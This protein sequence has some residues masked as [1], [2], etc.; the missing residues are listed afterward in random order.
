M[1][2]N[3]NPTDDGTLESI[4]DLCTNATDQLNSRRAFMS[5]TV[6]A[7]VGIGALSFAG[8]GITAAG[9]KSR[10]YGFTVVPPAKDMHKQD[11]KCQYPSSEHGFALYA[12]HGKNALVPVNLSSGTFNGKKASPISG[13]N[14]NTMLVGLDYRPSNGT[15]YALD[16]NGQL[17][18]ISMPK[19]HGNAVSAQPVGSPADY[20]GADLGDGIGFDFNP[21]ADA[22]RVV[23]MT[24][25]SF[26]TN[27]DDGTIIRQDPDTFYA[28]GDPNEGTAPQLSAAAYTNSVPDPTTTTLYD[29][30]SNLD[31]LVRQNADPN[32]PNTSELTTIGGLG[33][34]VAAIN[35]FDISGTTGTAYA[36]LTVDGKTGLYTV[37]LMSGK[38]TQVTGDG[39]DDTVT[40]IDVLNYALTLE[41]LEAAFYTQ[42]QQMFNECEIENSA[43]AKRLGDELQMSTYDYFNLIRDHEQTHV[44]TLTQVIKDLG[45][46]PVSGLEFEFPFETVEEYFA[47]AQTFENLG[48][49]AYDGAIALIE[50]PDLQTAGATI[51][52]VEAR[53][54]S[55]LNILNA[56]VPFPMAFDEP[57]TMEEV[58]AAAGQFIVDQ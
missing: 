19:K 54:A 5:N 8:S 24:S 7:G 28:K 50:N 13:V 56:D 23:T 11:S 58:L 12:K 10:I 43:A 17:Y 9:D 14:K 45:G 55:Y 42:G 16:E 41:K 46:E 47:L 27:A 34:D 6:K 21:V 30:D 40:D 52:T 4:T 39:M 53:H 51:A 36:V 49:S 35:G 37:D 38:A 32:S 22:I 44:E 2:A 48:V 33:I 25:E 26:V 20:S 1:T 57:K 18:T 15:L 3:N 31:V 29:I